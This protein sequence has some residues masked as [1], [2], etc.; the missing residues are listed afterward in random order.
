MIDPRLTKLFQVVP[1]D[2]MRLKQRDPGRAQ[3]A[4][5]KE[6]GKDAVEGRAKTLL[7]ENIAH[8]AEAQERLYTNG[9]Y[10]VLRKALVEA[11]LQLEEE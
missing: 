5:L 4:E 6:L 8:L 2:K 11:K 10:A 9:V 1:G 7:A 3:T